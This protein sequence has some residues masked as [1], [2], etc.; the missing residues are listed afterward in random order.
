MFQQIE[1]WEEKRNENFFLLD[2]LLINIVIEGWSLPYFTL[3]NII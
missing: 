1:F 3:K 2:F